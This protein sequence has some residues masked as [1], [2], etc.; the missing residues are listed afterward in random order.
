MAAA[1]ATVL[2]AGPT[3]AATPSISISSVGGQPVKGGS[4]REPL[5]GTVA[6]NGTSTA[7]GG[8]SSS[9]AQPLVADAG[10]SG[11]VKFGQ[12]AYLVGAGFGGAEPYTFAWSASAGRSGART[13]RRPP[14]TRPAWRRARTR[15]A[16]G[17]PMRPAR[18]RR[19]RVKVR[20]YDPQPR[21]IHDETQADVGVGTGAILGAGG[22]EMR[23]TFDV[24]AGLTR[25][26]AQATWTTIPNDYDMTIYDPAG[27]ERG[28]DGDIPSEPEDVSVGSPAGRHVDRGA[29]EVRDCTIGRSTRRHVA[30]GLRSATGGRHGRAVPLRDGRHADASTAR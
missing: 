25:F 14:S 27:V 13:P 21:V 24:P 20:V 6:V 29:P 9:P 26:D 17:S 15:S 4:V 16:C 12:P 3:L 8:G 23:F 19:T 11:F 28:S 1:F 22:N 10:D 18:P 30:G 5:S 2:V 7:S